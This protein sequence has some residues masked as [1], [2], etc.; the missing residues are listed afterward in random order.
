MLNTI[1]NT[2]SPSSSSS[3]I[4]ETTSTNV[5]VI[6]M[7]QEKNKPFTVIVGTKK[8]DVVIADKIKN[9]DDD[10]DHE[11]EEKKNK[12]KSIVNHDVANEEAN[13]RHGEQKAQMIEAQEDEKGEEKDHAEQKGAEEEDKTRNRDEEKAI[14]K[15]KNNNGYYFDD[16]TIEQKRTSDGQLIG[17]VGSFERLLLEFPPWKLTYQSIDLA[18]KREQIEK[19]KRVSQPVEIVLFLSTW[20]PMARGSVPPVIKA[21]KEAN[22]ENIQLKMIAL[23]KQKDDGK[24]WAQ[25]MNV[26]RVP[27]FI[28]RKDGR[29]VNRFVEFSPTQFFVDDLLTALL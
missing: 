8:D 7:P 22:N 13:E 4:V 9:N 14:V 15:P 1:R 12:R 6:V 19:L 17:D 3:S 25:A 11:E 29:E 28:V 10:E 27:T 5:D 18:D 24:G 26:K 2:P 20:C 21:L 23:S 16:E